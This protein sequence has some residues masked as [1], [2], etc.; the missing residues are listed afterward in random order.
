MQTGWQTISDEKYYLGSDGAMQTGWQTISD[1]KYYFGSDGAMRTGW[2]TISDEKYYFGSNGKMY[3]G[4]HTIDGTVYR[5]SDDGVYTPV[6]ICLDAGHYGKYNQSPVNSAYY[7]SEMT[8]KLHLYLKEA[9]ESYG[10]EVVTTRSDQATDLG[11]E[12]RGKTAEGCDLFIS[13][14]SNATTSSSNDAPLACCSIDGEVNTL[15]QTLADTIHEVMG[16]KQSG[17]IWNRVGNNGD[18]YGV[19]RGAAKVGV[20]GI[21]LE[22]SCHTNLAATNWLLVDSN[23]ETLAKA[24]AAVLATYFGIT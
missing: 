16:T 1:E 23:L 24:E 13:I 15:G 19:L 9:L 8:W 2:P 6:R 5:F 10:I 12:T 17:S 22:H 21:L 3:T 7:E 14:H 18:Y 4:N 11:L 20:S